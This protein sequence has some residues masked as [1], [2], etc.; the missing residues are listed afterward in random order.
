[1]MCQNNKNLIMK[2]YIYLSVTFFLLFTS[3]ISFGQQINNNSVIKISENELNSLTKVLKKYKTKQTAN[4]QDL[5]S[6]ATTILLIDSL[7]NNGI[8]SQITNKTFEENEEIITE[9]YTGSNNNSDKKLEIAQEENQELS[10]IKKELLSIQN[11][12]KNNEEILNSLKLGQRNLINSTNKIEG[13]PKTVI[14]TIPAAIISETTNKTDTIFISREKKDINVNKLDSLN[15]LK[16][17]E[18]IAELKYHLIQNDSLH[19]KLIE[20]N[21]RPKELSTIKLVENPFHSKKLSLIN[22]VFFKNNIS[23]IDEAQQLLLNEII[24]YLKSDLNTRIY[25]KGYASNDGNKNYNKLLSLK[26]TETVKAYFIKNGIESGRIFTNYFGIDY[27]QTNAEKAR[28]V[29]FEYFD[30][31]Q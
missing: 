18:K 30:L 20:L 1:M 23:T 3:S 26:R 14:K 16:L 8:P 15:I 11:Q 24:S 25:L 5:N 7:N 22:Q 21:E 9:V 27:S 13:T 28:R 29:D 4:N 19:L 2:Q 6:L 10:E 12:L 17:Q 31:I